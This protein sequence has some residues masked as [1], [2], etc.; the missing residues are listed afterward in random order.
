MLFPCS[1]ALLAVAVCL[2]KR[3]GEDADLRLRAGEEGL[4]QRRTRS[5][6]NNS[7]IR[8]DSNLFVPLY[9]FLQ[10]ADDPLALPCCFL[11]LTV[12]EARLLLW[13]PVPQLACR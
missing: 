10:C 13:L 12:L 11:S 6:R 3:A 8:Y 2:D 9:V 7:P 5:P 4:R 1:F